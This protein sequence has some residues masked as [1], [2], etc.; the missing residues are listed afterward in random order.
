MKKTIEEQGVNLVKFKEH[1]LHLEDQLN[2]EKQKVTMYKKQLDYYEKK[3]HMTDVEKTDFLQNAKSRISEATK[4]YQLMKKEKELCLVKQK[5]LEEELVMVKEEMEK[6]Y[7]QAIDK[8]KKILRLEDLVQYRE[9][10]I[11]LHKPDLLRK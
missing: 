10:Q 7:T 9:S 1:V 5:S 2:Q 8:D 11:M 4:S 3:S 6:L